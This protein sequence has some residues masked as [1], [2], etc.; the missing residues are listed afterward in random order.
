MFIIKC[1]FFFEMEECLVLEKI[2]YDNNEIIIYNKIYLF[3]DI[4]F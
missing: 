2:D 4:C 1:C 3:K